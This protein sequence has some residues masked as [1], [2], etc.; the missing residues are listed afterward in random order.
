[1][2]NAGFKSDAGKKH[3]SENHVRADFH[4]LVYV[5]GVLNRTKYNARHVCSCNISNSKIT[6]CRIGKE[7][8]QRKA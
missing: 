5:G 3:R 8:T 4:F 6:L 1:M 2:I 7:E